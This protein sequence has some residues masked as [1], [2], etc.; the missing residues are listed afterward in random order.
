MQLIRSTVRT[1]VNHALRWLGHSS[2]IQA[3]VNI[4]LDIMVRGRTQTK[5]AQSS[6]PQT[7][8]Q[9]VSRQTG[10]SKSPHPS[11]KN[12]PPSVPTCSSCGIAITDEVRALECERCQAGKWKCAAC[13]LLPTELY[14]QLLREPKCNL[15][16]FCDKCDNEIMENDVKNG[17]C[18]TGCNGH[19]DKI[20]KLV[21]VVEKLVDKLA[22]V[23]D[24][25][26]DKCDN[27]SIEKL[28]VRIS[29]LEERLNNGENNI[30][31]RLAAVDENVYRFVTDR[32]KA[33]EDGKSSNGPVVAME[34]AVKEE[35]GKQLVEDKD[36]EDRKQNVILYKVPEDL[37]A[38][39]ETRKGN[40]LRF[41]KD[42]FEVVFQKKI[43]D[44]DIEKLFRLGR[45]SREAEAARP[46]L[47][48]FTDIS[49]KDVAMRNVR[50][51]REAESRFSSV[52]ISHDL[53]PK[54]RDEI[55]VMIAD[56]KK[57]HAE[58]N[59]DEVENYRFIVV[60]QGSRKKVIKVR[61]QN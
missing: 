34:Q 9:S 31:H 49:V 42:M 27:R 10:E 7:S 26:R 55:K 28:E 44:S 59:S 24:K 30:E 14:D 38:D 5:T 23:E 51:L 58:N 57:E 18:N 12:A 29:Q 43:E 2:G 6:K 50:K 37:S 1:Y 56:A 54:Q 3:V 53:T 25:L 20:D 35:I 36:I 15:R 17:S 60:G 21:M 13:L 8:R 39:L 52:G 40:D 32:F 48:R 46:L 41:I 19:P 16:W 47:V 61:K 33:L 4:D 45:F 22:D 11:G